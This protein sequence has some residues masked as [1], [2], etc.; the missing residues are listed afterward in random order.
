MI[1]SIGANAAKIEH[2]VTMAIWK[3]EMQIHAHS[4][5][6]LAKNLVSNKNW[7]I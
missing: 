3:L 6:P 4:K 7:I 5:I 2:V 1:F